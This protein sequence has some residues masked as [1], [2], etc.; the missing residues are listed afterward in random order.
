MADEFLSQVAAEHQAYGK[1]IQGGIALDNQDFRQAIKILTEANEVLD[2]WLGHFDL[3]R[4][5][6][7]AGGAL[8]QADSEFDRCVN[9]VARCST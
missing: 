3:G 6:L 1:I 7:A 2:T 5:F 8:P 4:A 9:G